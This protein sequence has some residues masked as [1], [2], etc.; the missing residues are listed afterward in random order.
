MS[1]LH[2]H[3]AVDQYTRKQHTDDVYTACVLFITL[4]IYYSAHT[5]L[6]AIIG[7]TF[8]SFVI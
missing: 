5:D 4:L 6:L 1:K 7:Q 2:S 3:D 8:E